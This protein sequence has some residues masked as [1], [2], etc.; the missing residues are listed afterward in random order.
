MI[1]LRQFP[2]WGPEMPD[3]VFIEVISR[4]AD[5]ARVV[6]VSFVSDLVLRGHFIPLEGA[7]A[8]RD[9]LTELVGESAR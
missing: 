9:R 8:L 6:K 3:E 2:D 7:R 1:Y 4:P 5:G